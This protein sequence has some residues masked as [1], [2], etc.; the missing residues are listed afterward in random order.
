MSQSRF[1]LI[2]GL[3]ETY[4]RDIASM[5][6]GC[7]A[8]RSGMLRNTTTEGTNGIG[9]SYLLAENEEGAL[10]MNVEL[11]WVKKDDQGKFVG[12]ETVGL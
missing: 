4:V 8:L 5:L 6:G 12:Q 9:E 11:D 10:I 7:L 2:A 3:T 1:D